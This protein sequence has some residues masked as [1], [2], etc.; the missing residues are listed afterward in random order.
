MQKM[1]TIDENADFEAGVILP[2]DKPFEW[3]SSDVVRKVKFALRKIGY[4]KIKVGHAGTLDPLATG[5]LIL[6][7]GR[8]TKRVEEIQAMEKEYVADI[9]LGATTPSCDLEHPVDRTYPHEHINRD[10]IE[11]ALARLSGERL[12]TPPTY[13]A[14]MI[15][16]RRAYEYAREGS[17]IEMRQSLINIY[18]MQIIEYDHPHL[19]IRVRCSKGTYI[20]SLAREIGEE[21]QS[22]AYLSGLCRTKNGDTTIEKC[23][24][25]E[26][27]V[28]FLHSVK[29][30]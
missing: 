19:K 7:I 14:K 5:V 29:Q 13:S 23:L 15:D 12:Q 17:E 2:I 4:R 18:E 30:I 22:G 3:T 11:A 28:K 16:G 27:A 10:M 6:C 9:M 8:A 25:L 1:I 24:S 26:N 21:L 20:R